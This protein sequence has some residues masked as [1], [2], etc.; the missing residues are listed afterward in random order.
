PRRPRHADREPRHRVAARCGRDAGQREPRARPPSEI[1][2]PEGNVSTAALVPMRHHSER[3]LG[4]NFRVLGDRPLYQHIV[5][6]LLEVPEIDEVVIDTDSET[7]IEQAASAFPQVRV[8]L[9]PEHLRAGEIPMNDV[10]LNTIRQLDADVFL[11]THSTNP[12]L[13]AA[14]IS[15]ALR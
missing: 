4:K 3:V 9:R 15:A 14:T 11:Q 8:L 13:S 7:I 5:G 1:T 10:L 12:F 2:E 6:T